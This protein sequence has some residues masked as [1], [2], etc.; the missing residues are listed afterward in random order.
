MLIPPGVA[1]KQCRRT[2]DESFE[3]LGAYPDHEGCRTAPTADTR[4]R[5]APNERQA[6]SIAAC[7]APVQCPRWGARSPW[8]GGFKRLLRE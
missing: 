1:H 6:A 7:P 8:E 5:G 2:S 3:L 4:C